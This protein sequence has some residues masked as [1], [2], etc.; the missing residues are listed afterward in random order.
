MVDGV[1]VVPSR[2]NVDV[3]LESYAFRWVF[4]ARPPCDG[5]VRKSERVLLVVPT[6]AA[7]D[8]LREA[9]LGRDVSR[10]APY[11][12]IWHTSSPPLGITF[13]PS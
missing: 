10:I 9:G 8:P 4:V 11:R 1:A 6:E 13:V 5:G 3:G 12:A 2:R 7:S